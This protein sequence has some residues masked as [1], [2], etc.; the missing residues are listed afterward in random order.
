MGDEAR[1]D[2]LTAAVDT[3]PTD[4]PL[5]SGRVPD[6]TPTSMTGERY[7]EARSLARVGRYSEA[8]RILRPALATAPADANLLI[9]L[10]SVLRMQRDYRGALKACDAATQAAPGL[11]GAHAERA[12]NLIA[13]I[14]A[15]D[16]VAA[17]T[18]ATRLDPHDP[19]GHLVL[20]RALLCA[21][22]PDEARAVAQHGLSLDPSSV[23]ALL[24]VADVERDAGHRQVAE[25]A[26]RGA[27]ALDPANAYGRRLVAMLDAERHQARRAKRALRHAARDNPAHP[28]VV[29]TTRPLRSFLAGLRRWLAPAVAL[30]VVL[31]LIGAEWPTA[32]LIARALAAAIAVAILGLAARVLVP[33][34]RLPWRCLRAAPRLL[35][36]A[37][38]GG[39]LT[40]AAIVTL[41][42]WYAVSAWWPPIGL[43]LAA[44]AV[45]GGHGVAE[46]FGTRADDPGLVFVLR[47][48]GGAVR[49]WVRE[50]R[51]WW[52]TMWHDLRES[53][54]EPPPATSGP[55]RR[56]TPPVPPVS[57][58]GDLGSAAVV[59]PVPPVP[60]GRDL[61][62]AAVVPPV[63]P[64]PSGR[65][66]GS[67]AVVPPVPS[68]RD[69][70]SAAPVPPVPSGRDLGSAAPVPPADVE[71]GSRDRSPG[72]AR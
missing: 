31:V 52:R 41:L 51:E 25:A 6:E 70:G 61:G 48:L 62:S 11:A 57:S 71:S 43:A 1:I 15:R 30:V 58:G 34:G 59:P 23:E 18:E 66:L 63:P 36:G 45:L 37:T 26:A 19:T 54:T 46:S 65:D 9:L 29:S 72:S 67:A 10:G 28:D 60:S 16:A 14:R 5:P 17:A 4:L 40:L 35:R 47:A 8:E 68:G 39:L 21:R 20:A 55:S 56:P 27:L 3:R 44:V 53:W 22:R 49:G 24:T 38:A 69:L 12:E 7:L 2:G 50:F 42:I 32:H 64:V 13:L 33:A